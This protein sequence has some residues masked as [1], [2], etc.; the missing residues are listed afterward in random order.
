MFE[1]I[2]ILNI[3]TAWRE[4][5]QILKKIGIETPLL[6]ARLLLQ[7]AINI[8][9]EELIVSATR[10]LTTQEKALF[11]GM[12]KRRNKREPVSK[13]LGEKE[14]WGLKFKTTINN[15]D[16]RPDSETLIEA[17]TKSY[18]DVNR[19]L[20]ILDLGTG[21]G[22]LL[23]TLLYL[24][25][26][27]TGV[28]VDKSAE[29]LE[30]AKENAEKNEIIKRVEFLESDWF[31]KVEGKFDIIICNPPYIKTEAINYLEPE[32]RFF[33]PEM[34]LDGGADGLSCYREIISNI[35]DYLDVHGKAFFEIGQWQDAQ[36][37]EIIEEQAFEVIEIKP[38]LKSIPRIIVF[39][40]PYLQ[41]VK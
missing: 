25:S 19:E 7:N 9:Y 17:V 8:T 28:G 39:G 11:I 41:I 10:V 31:E 30:I 15:L 6:D 38:D 35:D 23:V 1:N 2:E 16:P 22:C 36:I 27:A 4:A 37:S 14:F 26:N 32:V 40:K 29:A 13:I 34:A 20:R 5:A 12:M 18:K 33:D 21:S 24:Y 3:K